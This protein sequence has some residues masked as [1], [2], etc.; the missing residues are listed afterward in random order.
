MYSKVIHIHMST[1]FKII[2]PYR[3]LQN[4]EFPVLYSMFL[5]VFYFMYSGV[6]MSIPVFPFI[7]PLPL[8]SG[9]HEL[10]FEICNPIS[11]LWINSFVPLF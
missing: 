1:L 8:Y 7:P 5:L 10:V 4:I 11:V 3:S 9:N 2:F 6:Y